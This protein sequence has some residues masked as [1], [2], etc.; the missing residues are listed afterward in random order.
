VVDE[1]FYD[2]GDAEPALRER[3]AEIR[4]ARGRDA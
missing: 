3:L 4:A 1:R 2:P